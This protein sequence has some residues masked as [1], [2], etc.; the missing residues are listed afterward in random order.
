MVIGNETF[1]DDPTALNSNLFP[2][3]AK[4]DTVSVGVVFG[5]VGEVIEA[6]A[7][8]LSA[9]TLERSSPFSSFDKISE[10]SDPTNTEMIAGELVAP[11][12]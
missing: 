2:V 4:E 10:R 11:K 6:K 5:K 9:E 1:C 8:H 12:R 7:N 3:K